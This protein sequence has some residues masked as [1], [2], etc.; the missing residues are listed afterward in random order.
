M[1]QKFLPAL[2]EQVHAYSRSHRILI[3]S[4][5][6]IYTRAESWLKT[7]CTLEERKKIF[8]VSNL[9]VFHASKCDVLWGSLKEVL[10]WCW[11]SAV[12]KD[13]LPMYLGDKSEQ[14]LIQRLESIRCITLIRRI[15]WNSKS[16]KILFSFHYEEGITDISNTTKLWIH[17]GTDWNLGSVLWEN[18]KCTR[19]WIIYL[20]AGK[21][22]TCLLNH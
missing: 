20:D 19:I 8:P 7:L 3:N 15:W 1:E 12:I 18:K 10:S 11:W 4:C 13:S 21:K 5:T 2:L 9:Y 16:W 22:I 17:M 6:I 14:Q